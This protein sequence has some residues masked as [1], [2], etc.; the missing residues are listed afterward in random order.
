ML[1][2]DNMR[3]VAQLCRTG[4]RLPDDLANWLAAS[5]QSFLNHQAGSLND[6]F[7]LRNARGGVPWRM[8][9]SMRVRDRV[10]RELSA[11]HFGHL[12]LSARAGRIH[13]LSARYAAASWRFDRERDAMPA[14]YAG[15]PLAFLWLAFKSGAVMPLGRRQL[16]KILAP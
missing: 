3:T 13:E 5:L 12:S 14:G 15:T 10:L 11:A 1:A 2:I 7:G 16:Q 9:A 6:A 8:E 4:E